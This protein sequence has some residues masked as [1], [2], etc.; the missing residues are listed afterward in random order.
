[1]RIAYITEGFP[2]R[3]QPFILHKVVELLKRGHQVTVFTR[4]IRDLDAHPDM[5][6]DLKVNMK[7][8]KL[9]VPDRVRPKDTLRGLRRALQ[10]P[11]RML[12][13]ARRSLWERDRFS[14]LI[15]WNKSLPFLKGGFDLIH[16][17][18]G[19][20]G[21][22]YIEVASALNTP[23]IVNF[24]GTDATVDLQRTPASYCKVFQLASRYITCSEYIK[25]ILVGHGISPHIV[26]IVPE[27]IDTSY[28]QFHDR[29]DQQGKV[30]HILSVGRFH[31]VKGFNYALD[32]MAV[33]QKRGLRFKYILVGGGGRTDE[34][35]MAIRDQGLADFVKILGT[36]DREQVRR[37]LYESD[38]FLLSSLT[39]NLNV[40][41]LEAQASGLPVVATN[42]GGI[43]EQV[44]DG[45][46]GL[47]VP[48][49]SPEAMAD[50]LQYLMEHPEQRLKMGEKGREQVENNFSMEIL[51]PRLLEVYEKVAAMK[52][53]K[54][55]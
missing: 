30:P 55:Q 52:I 34:F 27:E 40:A 20:L 9:P 50:K 19:Q 25:G 45:E 46:T 39:E 18:F 2:Q 28:F 3:N 4:F 32:A 5:R 41:I 10:R 6:T 11:D 29:R 54:Q 37:L 14:P 33:L 38:I 42:V 7:I 22:D 23:M 48:P 24:R 31:W 17:H 36:V 13:S 44:S 1:M 8:V 51:F 47:L 12:R 49:R 21:R 43:P 16:A 26:S 15:M 53:K 35:E